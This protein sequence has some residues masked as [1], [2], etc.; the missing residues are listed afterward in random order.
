MKD[1]KSEK[2]KLPEAFSSYEEAAEFWDTHDSTD[3]AEH[4]VAV[5]VDV[6]LK[7]RHFEIEVDEDV[8]RALEKRAGSEHIP[9][10]RLANDL[11]KREL[12]HR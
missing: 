4:L 6:D 12:V 10:G 8:I 3:Y 7:R 2:D 9:A 5:E 11:L 1:T